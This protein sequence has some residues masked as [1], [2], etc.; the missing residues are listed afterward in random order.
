[1]E[2]LFN[3]FEKLTRFA[4]P[5]GHERKFLEYIKSECEKYCDSAAFDKRGNLVCRKAKEG[6][7]KL[8]LAA[9]ADELCIL[10]TYAE[11]N[12]FYRIHAAGKACG[13]LHAKAEFANG[14]TG[15][16]VSEEDTPVQD[17]NSSKLLVDIGAKNKKEAEKML[18]PLTAGVPL[19][20]A[21]KIGSR[22]F[23]KAIDD[24]VGCL[25]LI[26]LIKTVQKSDYDLYF[27]FTVEE[28]LG[29]RGAKTVGFEIEP[30][31]AIAI[32]VSPAADGFASKRSGIS[33]GGG[34]AI[35]VLDVGT[36][37]DKELNEELIKAAK[38]SKSGYQIDVATMGR[39]DAAELQFVKGGVKA[40]V[41][42]VATRYIHT[43]NEEADLNDVKD[44]IATLKTFIG[45]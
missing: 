14:V 4:A 40:T 45:D 13:L 20:H 42:S 36:V 44:V 8:L 26:E 17:I 31:I 2:R 24:K 1:M 38:K 35:K 33:L 39:T 11:D 15:V 27:C 12:G 28:E 3:E 43:P 32:D 22:F 16:I 9:H 29:L 21:M 37:C 18:P 7:K 10:A 5:S 41:V 34:A 23:S 25:I 6:A 30:D 19:S